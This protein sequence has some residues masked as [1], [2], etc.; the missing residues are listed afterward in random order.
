MDSNHALRRIRPACR[1]HGHLPSSSGGGIRTPVTPVTTGHLATRPLP[2]VVCDLAPRRRIE[3]L[4]RPRRGRVC[5]SKRPG[6]GAEAEGLEPPTRC[7]RATRFRNELQIQ[8]GYLPVIRVGPPDSNGTS[9][10]R[11]RCATD[12]HHGPRVWWLQT[13]ALRRRCGRPVH[14]TVPP[15]L[16]VLLGFRSP[17]RAR[18]DSNLRRSEGRSL[19]L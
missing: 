5:A 1:S 8:P 9:R 3:L 16:L 11:A 19:A 10:V 14:S 4:S 7:R 15:L 13:V 6:R 17:R 18:Q 2:I 12:L